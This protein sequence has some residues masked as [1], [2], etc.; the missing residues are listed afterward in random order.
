MPAAAEGCLEVAR[1]GSQTVVTRAFATSPLRLLTPA[2]HGHAA[3]VYTSTFGGGL[4]D[5]DRVAM[6][7]EVT[8]GST[9][10]LTTQAS[11]KVY[12]SPRGTHSSLVARVE[13]GGLLIVAPDPLVC[14]A[15]A[16]YRQQQR[17]HLSS[18]GALIVADCMVSGRCA[19]GERWAFAEYV[20]TLD[21]TIDDRLLVHDAL[22]LRARDGDLARR[23]GRF[24]AL[25]VA[26]VAG[27]AL[28]LEAERLLTAT[29][30][31]P[32]VRNSDAL[33]AA[34]PLGDDG[35]LL[36]A[37]GVSG[38]RVWHAV[39]SLLGFIPSHLGDDPWSRK[40]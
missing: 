5:G 36:R 30:S 9:A 6:E 21:V 23:F 19:A 4:V 20:S 11:T 2:N 27:P 7:V 18:S 1:N 40:W 24:N 31:Q 39:R 22:A 15:D 32:V 14:F 33:V 26:V 35:C 16:R 3:W 8:R 28:R 12:K 37:A 34:S 17:F 25:A 38:E 29:S 13:A 10:F